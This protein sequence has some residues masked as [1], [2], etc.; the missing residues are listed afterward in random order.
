MERTRPAKGYESG[1][2]KAILRV[3]VLLPEEDVE[4][5]QSM[6][7]SS[8]ANATIIG[9]WSSIDELKSLRYLTRS[10]AE[11]ECKKQNTDPG[12][13]PCLKE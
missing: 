11:A 10:E 3:E 8:I 12:F 7:L 5:L 13:F 2:V 9:A 1:L 4:R 6:S